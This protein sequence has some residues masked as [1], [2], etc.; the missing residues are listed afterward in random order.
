MNFLK[1]GFYG[2]TLCV[3]ARIYLVFSIIMFITMAFQNFGNIDLY[4]L[5]KIRCE[6]PNL[7][8]VFVIKILYTA[9][10]TIII[11]LMCNANQ[12]MLAWALVVYPLL[13]YV[14][15]LLELMFQ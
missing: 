5:G 9:F 6:A 15:L 13:L 14:V 7:Y 4:C 1:G 8:L 3:P 2:E 11:Q 12:P 10:W